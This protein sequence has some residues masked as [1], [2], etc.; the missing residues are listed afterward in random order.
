LAAQ[1]VGWPA[2]FGIG[3]NNAE[4]KVAQHER[5]KAVLW[6][7]PP[8]PQRGW[9]ELRG[10]LRRAGTRKHKRQDS[11]LLDDGGEVRAEE[12]ADE[13]GD[14]NLSDVRGEQEILRVPRFDNIPPR[15]I[16]PLVERQHVGI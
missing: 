11:R 13:G 5:K 7:S 4:K 8:G 10:E 12:A 6:W 1:F 9:Q 2:K 3:T 15:R 16:L 14:D